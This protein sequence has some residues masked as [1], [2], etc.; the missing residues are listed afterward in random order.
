MRTRSTETGATSLACLIR[1]DPRP[2]K[3]VAK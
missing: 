1:A 2:N 3:S